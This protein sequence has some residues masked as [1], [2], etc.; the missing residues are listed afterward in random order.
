MYLDTTLNI[1]IFLRGFFRYRCDLPNE[2]I[3]LIFYKYKSL[4]HPVVYLLQTH[5]Q[6]IFKYYNI[7]KHNYSY[8]GKTIE[9][10]NHLIYKNYKNLFLLDNIDNQYGYDIGPLNIDIIKDENITFIDYDYDNDSCKLK[11]YIHCN[12]K[13]TLRFGNL[14][15]EI[16][17]IKDKLL[18][19]ELTLALFNLG[20]K[21]KKK[22]IYL[23]PHTNILDCYYCCEELEQD[24]IYHNGFYD[25]FDILIGY[26]ET[27]SKKLKNYIINCDYFSY[28]TYY[29][30]L[31][32][33]LKKRNHSIY[34][35]FCYSKVVIE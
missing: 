8:N 34:C 17:N 15:Y 2:I 6:P 35:D 23:K 12:K 30:L 4:K 26:N 20:I 3:N 9:N 22:L 10:R 11:Q 33:E 28:T 16:E 25:I 14:F 19:S 18:Q 32:E 1:Q 31:E 24:F 21:E 13:P 27:D 7:E 5:F 29:Q